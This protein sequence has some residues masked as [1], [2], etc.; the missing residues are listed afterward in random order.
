MRVADIP[1]LFTPET[2]CKIVARGLRAGPEGTRAPR[3]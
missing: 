1:K 3:S 2:F